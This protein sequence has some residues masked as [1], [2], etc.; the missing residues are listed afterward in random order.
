LDEL[1]L[2]ILYGAWRRVRGQERQTYERSHNSDRLADLWISYVCFP[3]YLGLK[4]EIA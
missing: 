4:S 3:A 2:G 1:D